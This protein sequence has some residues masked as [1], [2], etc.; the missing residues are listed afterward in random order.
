M[1][2]HWVNIIYDVGNNNYVY[3][4]LVTGLET[5]GRVV[6]D[7]NKLFRIAFKRELPRFSTITYG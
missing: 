4:G 3:Q 7:P 5:N 6:I 2:K 1:K